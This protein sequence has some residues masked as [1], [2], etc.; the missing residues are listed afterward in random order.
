[1][2]ESI[3]NLALGLLFIWLVIVIIRTIIGTNK[4]NKNMETMMSQLQKI[5]SELEEMNRHLPK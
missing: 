3:T 2:F 1:M 4:I 5:I